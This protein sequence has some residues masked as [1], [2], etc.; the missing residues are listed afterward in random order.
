MYENNNDHIQF[1]FY[2]YT[3]SIDEKVIL[4]SL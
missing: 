3:I 4:K 1:K 2:F